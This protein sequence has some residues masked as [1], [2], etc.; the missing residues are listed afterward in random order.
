MTGRWSIT[1]PLTLGMITLLILLGGFGIWSVKAQI[2]G[3]VIASG[4]V[5]VAQNHQIVQHPDGGTVAELFVKEGTS[6]A[7]GDILI[8]LD[9]RDLTSQLTLIEGQYLEIVAR[10]ARLEAERDDAS[11]LTFAA[12]LAESP[13]KAAKTLMQGQRRLFD[14]RNDSQAQQLTRLER[15]AEQVSSQIEGIRAQKSALNTQL[16]LIEQELSDQ[17]RLLDQGL[18]Q[19][20]RVLALRRNQAQLM[21][22][23]GELDAGIA[24]AEGRI[25]E[26]EIEALALKG[27]RREEAIAT[28]RDLTYQEGQLSEQIRHLK[29]QLDRLEIRAP[30]AGL[31]YGLSVFGPQSVIKPADPVLSVVPQDRPLIVT[32]RVPAIHIDQVHPGQPVMLKITALDQRHTP[33]MFGN[34][35]SISADAFQDSGSGQTYYRIETHIARSELNKLSETAKLVPGMPVDAYIQTR[36]RTPI[37]YLTAPLTEYFAKAFRE[38]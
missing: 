9:K 28:L 27:T 24:Q 32:S 21:G 22:Q 5:E 17:Q 11:D 14:A 29:G 26:L 25:T 2:T 16:T 7:K 38:G 4:Q 18:A 37:A 10:R 33:D 8:R 1:G 30:V 23:V 3:A 34:V 35:A 6:V 13:S 20:S 31:I 15:R 19:A 36:T 12:V